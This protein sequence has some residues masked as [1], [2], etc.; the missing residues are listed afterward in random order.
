MAAFERAFPTID[1]PQVAGQQPASV[2]LSLLQQNA[3]SGLC[4]PSR[5]TGE[6]WRGRHKLFLARESL[7]AYPIS[8]CLNRRRSGSPHYY[9]APDLWARLRPLLPIQQLNMQTTVCSVCE[10]RE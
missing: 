10:A 6:P 5:R 3:P 8:D 2:L 7:M 9:D 4:V 1:R